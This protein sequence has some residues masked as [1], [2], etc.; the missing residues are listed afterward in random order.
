MLYL[1]HE[2]P[3]KNY[4]KK[5]SQ[6]ATKKRPKGWLV[7]NDLLAWSIMDECVSGIQDFGN[8]A[9]MLTRFHILKK[10][11]GPIPVSFS[12]KYTKPMILEQLDFIDKLGYDH[13]FVSTEY[14]FGHLKKLQRRMNEININTKILPDKYQTSRNSYQNIILFPLSGEK[15]EL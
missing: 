10:Y 5:Y 1:N 11:D 14:G 7:E 3:V 4:I 13:A 8:Y 12:D 2:T 6:V 9:R 15:F